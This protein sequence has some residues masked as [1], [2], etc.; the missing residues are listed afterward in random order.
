MR[1]AAAQL[2]GTFAETAAHYADDALLVLVKIM[3]DVTVS[4]SARVRCAELIIDRAHG[5][6]AP[7][8]EKP[9]DFTPLAERLAIYAREEQIEASA[10]KVVEFPVDPS[11]PR[12]DH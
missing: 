4:A 1:E 2:R 7:P 8:A 5:K 6:A 10:D 11:R 3:K 9:K 12:K